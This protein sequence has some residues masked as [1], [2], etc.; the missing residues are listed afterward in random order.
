MPKHPFAPSGLTKDSKILILGSFP[1]VASREEGFYYAHPQNRFWRVLELLFK[2][3][4]VMPNSTT[5]QAIFLEQNTASHIPKADYKHISLSM[6]SMATKIAFLK[7]HLFVLWDIVYS[8]EIIGSSDSTLKNIV[9]NDV[10]N[11]LHSSKI[12]AICLN[13]TKATMLFQKYCKNQ[14]LSLMLH[15]HSHYKTLTPITSQ[16]FGREIAIFSLPS[17]SPANAKY[18]LDNLLNAWKVLLEI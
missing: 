1:S 15:S 7:S 14:N 18:S 5:P 3:R 8:C 9:F 2:E 4:S 17:T 11:L 13:G 16:K 12:K 6:Q 10:F